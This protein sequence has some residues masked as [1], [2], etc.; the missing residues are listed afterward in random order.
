MVSVPG[1]LSAI[2]LRPPLPGKV[3][4]C[5]S[6]G[7]RNPMFREECVG[8]PFLFHGGFARRGVSASGGNLA[9]F[10]LQA[11]QAFIEIRL[12]PNAPSRP[13]GSD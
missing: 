13:S 2:S 4:V 7:S 6:V 11:H 10:L 8:R 1:T 5:G 3:N 12:L 9:V